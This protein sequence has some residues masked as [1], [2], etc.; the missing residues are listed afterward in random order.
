MSYSMKR[1][2]QEIMKRI[3]DGKELKHGQDPVEYLRRLERLLP[4][5]REQSPVEQQAQE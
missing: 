3:L 4:A 5:K 2:H 1:R